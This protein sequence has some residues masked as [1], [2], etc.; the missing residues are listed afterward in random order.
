MITIA[1]IFARKKFYTIMVPTDSL[2]ASQML[3]SPF[4]QFKEIDVSIPNT[5]HS[6]HNST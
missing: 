1:T 3:V 6:T 2:L 4:K 5:H